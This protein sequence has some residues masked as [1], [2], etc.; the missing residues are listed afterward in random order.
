[1]NGQ[2]K[3]LV[4]YMDGSDT[5]FIIPVY[6]RN[7]DWK[8]ENCKQLYDDLKRVIKDSRD[9][10][11]FG[12]IV[13]VVNTKGAS[14][15]FLIIDGQQRITTISLLFL[16]LV[17][18]LK[19]KILTDER[20]NLGKKI[21]ETYLLDPYQPEEK[22]VKLKPIKDDQEAFLKL[23]ETEDEYD[24]TSNVTQNYLYFYNRI[25][26]EFEEGGGMTADE[27][28]SAVCSLEVIDISLDPLKDDAQ[29]IFES[30]NSTGLG[31][32][33]GDKIRNYIL[34]GLDNNSQEK[35]YKD[36]WNK[37]E[38]NTDYEVSDFARHYLTV[39]T[40]K[41]PA[42]KNVYG[43][44]KAYVETHQT[45]TIILLEDMTKYSKYYYA[46]SH[47]TIG[48]AD[49]NNTF[50][51]LNVLDMSVSI[52]YFLSLLDYMDEVKLSKEELAEIVKTIEIFIFRRLVC[53]V[54]TNSLNKIFAQ[55][56]RDCLKYKSDGVC[57]ADVL[58]YILTR[59]SSS[60]R[61][62]KDNEFLLNIEEKD[63]YSMQAK[64][65]MYLFDR[66]ENRNTVEHTNVIENMQSGTYTIEH[67]MPQTLSGAWKKALGDDYQRVYDT[68]INRIANL[69]LTGYNS[70]YKNRPFIDK[71]DTADGFR[72]SH[73]HINSFI[74]ECD[75]WTEDELKERNEQMKALFLKLWP[76]PMTDFV[77]EIAINEIHSLD[78]DFDFKGKHLVAFIFLDTPY[79]TNVWSEMYQQVVKQMIELDATII[80]KYAKSSS[81]SGLS[82][83]FTTIETDGFVQIDDKLFLY[84]ASSTMSKINCL[85]KLFEEYDIDSSELIM[86]IQSE[87]N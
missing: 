48:N 70:Q 67:I 74:A 71:R 54:P 61:L 81:R 20:G 21:E 77:P 44:F 3:P 45:K 58:K 60:G 1:M 56:H 7:Y 37:I 6:Q 8:I 51:R 79:T 43:M 53:A 66:L 22:K 12:S 33:E 10:H 38:K 16:A 85:K 78:E 5:R 64:N 80:Y 52:P 18:L 42:I 55:L 73:L 62:P 86:E 34:M 24:K 50:S 40:G 17:N 46:I 30:L 9:S 65:K 31:L 27:L 57:Y 87:D 82:L 23:F 35:Y 15:E 26:T 19:K 41:T 36:Y 4:K 59:K 29:L 72:D 32:S 11:F 47:A 84:V 39:K 83:H 13:S 14:S 76:Y 63:F 75:K 2:A 28:F 69:T 68:W 49:V 25:K